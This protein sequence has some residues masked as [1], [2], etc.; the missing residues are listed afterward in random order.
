MNMC[1]YVFLFSTTPRGRTW[2]RRG[3]HRGGKQ[4]LFKRSQVACRAWGV[5][6]RW[7]SSSR[8]RRWKGKW[9]GACEGWQRGQKQPREEIKKGEERVKGEEREDRQEGKE[10]EAAR[11]EWKENQEGAQRAPW[12]RR[13]KRPQGKQAIQVQR[14]EEWRA[15]GWTSQASQ[16]RWQAS[17]DICP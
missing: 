11:E 15:Q 5:G 16:P 7:S 17:S 9:Q 8:L 2:K 4:Q 3:P 10:G 1:V 12:Q 14:R 6:G 13:G